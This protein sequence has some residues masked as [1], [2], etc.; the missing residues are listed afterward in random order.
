MKS[1]ISN[2]N[3]QWVINI[4]DSEKL[5]VIFY[6]RP[7]VEPLPHRCKYCGAL[8]VTDDDNCLEK[9]FYV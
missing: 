7:Y 3:N 1:F 4:R 5:S 8:T 2:E 9:P 6:F